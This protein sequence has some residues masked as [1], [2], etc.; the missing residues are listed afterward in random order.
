[1]VDSP[2]IGEI[3]ELVKAS[4]EA[5]IVEAFKES[6]QYIEELVKACLRAE[7]N[8]YGTEPSYHHR[9]KMPYLTYLARDTIRGI[10][11]TCVIEHLKN[12]KDEIGEKVKEK[13]QAADVKSWLEQ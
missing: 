7:V 4:I 5:K 3:S 13:L 10:A 11:R 12:M 1:M 9:E 8:E 6:P 2:K